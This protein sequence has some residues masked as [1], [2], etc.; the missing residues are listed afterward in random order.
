MDEQ[1]PRTRR[2][3]SLAQL[4]PNFLTVGAICAGLTAIRFG[5]QGRFELSVALIVFAALLDGIDG[6]IA[7]LLKSES[8][9]GAELDSLADFLN[10]GVAAPLTLYLW[11][12][13]DARNAG[14]IAVLVYAIC[15][16]LRLARFNVGNR[17]ETGKAEA[18]HFIGVPSPAGAL[19]AML[20]L[21]VGFLVPEIA[22]LP[23]VVVGLWMI[24]C[25]L[26][27]ISRVPTPS[28][29]TAR[30]PADD[31]KF[32]VIGFVAILAALLTYPWATL[33]AA[34]VGYIGAI[35]FAWHRSRAPKG[36]T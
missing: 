25:G 15:C 10:F 11:A 12:L 13:Q 5:F 35:V 17:A 14:W 2:A 19:L 23:A 27:M 8:D 28:F 9:I 18:A 4:L 20:P 26:L 29:K 6:R 1:P 32:V 30:I 33:I 7:R 21:Y 31:V 34:A 36:E 3:F 24:A 16:V 22:P